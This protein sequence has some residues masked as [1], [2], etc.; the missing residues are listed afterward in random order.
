M[1]SRHKFYSTG[2]SA[3]HRVAAPEADNKCGSGMLA[4][5]EQARGWPIWLLRAVPPR[6]G[7]S[8]EQQA[9]AVR[10]RMKRCL[11]PKQLR[12]LAEARHYD[13]SWNQARFTPQYHEVP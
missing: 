3:V 9:A 13:Q 4:E 10:Q 12:T 11:R 1:S 7:L 2:E 8:N 5:G 6:V